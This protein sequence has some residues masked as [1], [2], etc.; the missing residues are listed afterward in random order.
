[1]LG[2]GLHDGPVDDDEMLGCGFDVAALA[3]VARVEQE[4]RPFQTDPIAAPAALPGQLH[5][6][7]LAQQPFLHAQKP[8]H[9][10]ERDDAK[11]KKEKRKKENEMISMQKK[12]IKEK[13][14]SSFAPLTL[15]Q[16]RSIGFERTCDVSIIIRGALGIDA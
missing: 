1:M 5:L 7:F 8:V 10:A 16:P 14:N 3:G 11:S 13:F 12:N 9:E 15:L 2:Y 4:R 6:V